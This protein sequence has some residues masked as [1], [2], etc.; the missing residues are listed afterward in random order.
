MND[1]IPV[2]KALPLI[3]KGMDWLSHIW[4]ARESSDSHR[5]NSEVDVLKRVLKDDIIQEHLLVEQANIAGITLKARDEVGANLSR[6]DDVPQ[7][8]WTQ[9]RDRAKLFNDDDMQLLFARVL[10]GEMDK[11]GSFSPVTI[12]VLSEMNKGIATR[13]RALCSCV[14]K[15]GIMSPNDGR[16]LE[17]CSDESVMA[18]I[19]RSGIGWYDSRL[20]PDILILEDVSP[21][22]YGEIGLGPVD[23]P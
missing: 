6:L 7:Q 2:D 4:R 20:S 23:K 22:F 12:N 18:F 9:W 15:V 11:R 17:E 16:Y 8:W 14:Y 13:F 10:A 1:D 19:T 21:S 5:F 3:Q